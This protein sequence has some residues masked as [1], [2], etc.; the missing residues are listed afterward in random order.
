MLDPSTN[1]NPLDTTKEHQDGMRLSEATDVS[2]HVF[3]VTN[4]QLRLKLFAK[5]EVRILLI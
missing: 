5:N 2:K 3:Y 1:V 4:S